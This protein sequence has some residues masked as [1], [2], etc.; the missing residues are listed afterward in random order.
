M[1]RLFPRFLVVCVAA[2]FATGLSWASGHGTPAQAEALAHRA[3]AYIKANGVQKAAQEFT[4]GTSF[5]EGDLYIAFTDLQGNVFGHGGNPK[6]VGKN[7]VGLKDPDGKPFFQMLLDL[8][9][10]QGKGWSQEYKFLNP[11]T[12]KIENKAMYVERIDDHWVG[13]GV[14]KE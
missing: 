8:A 2:W 5:K 9:K 10:N 3:V 13:V 4:K 12:K 11:V 14:Y 1:K 7:L 6:L